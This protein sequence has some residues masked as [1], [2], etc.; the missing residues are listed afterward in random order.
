VRR[1][2]LPCRRGLA[3]S[4]AFAC[5]ILLAPVASS[6]QDAEE[7]PIEDASGRALTAL[8]TGN[9]LVVRPLND[10]GDAFGIL[11]LKEDGTAVFTEMLRDAKLTPIRWSVDES[12]RLCITE[13][14]EPGQRKDCGLF[15]IKGGDLF[16]Y[17]D[18]GKVEHLKA[19]LLRGAPPE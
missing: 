4:T 12:E 11:H 1:Y 2:R 17:G 6:A 14:L 15:R 18:N 13:S 5:A 16:I 10:A 7:I 19:R 9:T 8:L 3:A